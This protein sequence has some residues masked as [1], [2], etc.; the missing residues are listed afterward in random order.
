[1]GMINYSLR[2]YDFD[3]KQ[4][5]YAAA[6]YKFNDKVINPKMIVRFDCKSINAI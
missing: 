4:Q 6:C 1:M 5:N 2:I 3:H